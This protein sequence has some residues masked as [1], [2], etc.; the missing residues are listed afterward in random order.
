MHCLS[1]AEGASLAGSGAA[2]LGTGRLLCCR[3]SSLGSCRCLASACLACGLWCPPRSLGSPK[4]RSAGL[5]QV[6]AVP[7]MLRA[8]ARL[9]PLPTRLGWAGVEPLAGSER[10]CTQV[11]TREL[12]DGVL[13]DPSV[14]LLCSFQILVQKAAGIKNRSCWVKNEDKSTCCSCLRCA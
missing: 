6:S 10:C 13:R 5:Q 3:I 11:R 12:V 8:P 9:P 2:G 4:A 1:W 7:S 14:W